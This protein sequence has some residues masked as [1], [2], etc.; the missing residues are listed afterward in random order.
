MDGREPERPCEALERAKVREAR[1]AA[2]SVSRAAVDSPE[3]DMRHPPADYP[4]DVIPGQ[5]R[6]M[7]A[8]PMACLAQAAELLDAAFDSDIKERDSLA[9]LARGWMRLAELS[10]SIQAEK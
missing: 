9:A 5:F 2:G 8:D 3:D 4:E 7:A 1:E 6:R 10:N